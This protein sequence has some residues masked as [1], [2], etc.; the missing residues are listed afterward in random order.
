MVTVVVGLLTCLVLAV[1]VV[2]VVAVPARRSG[3]D[4]LTERGESVVG[5]LVEAPRALITR[6]HR[7]AGRHAASAGMRLESAQATPDR[8]SGRP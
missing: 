4:L 7:P 3:R 5:G 1:V 6:D 2:A 8:V